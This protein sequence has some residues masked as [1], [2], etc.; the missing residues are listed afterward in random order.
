[1]YVCLPILVHHKHVEPIFL[2]PGHVHPHTIA[3]ELEVHAGI[4]D[5][6]NSVEAKAGLALAK[7]NGADSDTWVPFHRYFSG[8]EE[9]WFMLRE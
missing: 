8:I 9:I 5:I 4:L 7:E 3:A 1:M 2:V 6:A